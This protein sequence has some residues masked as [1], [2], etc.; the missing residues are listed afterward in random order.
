MDPS[1]ESIQVEPEICHQSSSTDSSA[2]NKSEE[3]KRASA[4]Q[5]DK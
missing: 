5:P 1:T 2:Y 4:F 3:E